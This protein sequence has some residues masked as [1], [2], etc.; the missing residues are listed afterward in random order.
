M[1]IEPNVPR[2]VRGFS[3]SRSRDRALAAR[4]ARQHGV[5]AFDDLLEVGFSTDQIQRTADAHRLHRVHRGVYAIGHNLLSA[6]GHW[7]AAVLARG[8]DALLSHRSCGA[9]AGIHRTAIAYAEVTVPSQRAPID[10]VRTYVSARL[11]PQDRDE[12]DGIPCTSLART[13]LDLAAILPR[14][15][16]ERACDEAETQR[17]FDLR[18]IHDV[19]DRSL[20]CRGTA[21][22]RAVLREH[23][24]GTTLTRPGLEERTLAAL[25]RCTSRDRRS[26]PT[27]SAA[28]P[29]RSRSTSSGAASGSC[30]KPTAASFTAHHARSNATAARRPTSFAPATA[31]CAPLGC[32]SNANPTRSR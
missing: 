15:Q 3:S 8:A 14:R 5:V 26:T 22:L 1:E 9:L 27:S 6:K 31:C 19:L 10:G 11:Q 12:I 7:M 18:A 17:L 24:I 28:T 29:S 20:G 16:L 13:L 23:A 25:D 4:A 30:S 21:K 2:A 32:R